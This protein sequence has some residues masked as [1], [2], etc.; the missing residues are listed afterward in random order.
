MLLNKLEHYNNKFDTTVF[1]S[2]ND[3][4]SSPG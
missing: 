4:L 3:I 2:N 1:K